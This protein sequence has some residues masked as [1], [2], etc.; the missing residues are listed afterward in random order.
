MRLVER[1]R[2]ILVRPRSEWPLIATEPDDQAR[3][4]LRYVAPLAA[5]PAL[6]AF[7]GWSVVGVS[8]SVGTFR[9]PLPS[10]LARAGISYLFSFV[11]VY[12]TALAID[13]LA[14]L[15]GAQ[16]R[17]AHALKLA[18]YSFTPVWLIGIV[19]VIPGLRFLS[20]L[21]L[22]AVRLVWT[23]LPPLM[24]APRPKVLPYA[25]TV[26]ALTFLV[27]LAMAFIQSAITAP[28]LRGA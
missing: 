6:A 21:G 2:N 26:V 16:R 4:F 14:P 12:V 5:I 1:V 10:G 15:F 8:V 27:V 13:L 11:I 7:I 25:L 17:F 28:P 18:A 19:L 9:E 23:G 22:Y 3:L 20:I 24:G